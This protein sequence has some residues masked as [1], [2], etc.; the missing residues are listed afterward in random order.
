MASLCLLNV[1]GFSQKKIYKIKPGENIMDFIP[2]EEVYAYASF[3]NGTVYLKGDRYSNAKLNYNALFGD[4]QFI[5]DQGDTLGLADEKMIQS[6]VINHDT[7]YYDKGYLKL[8]DNIGG[9]KLASMKVFSF[10]NR[11]KVGGF[12]ELSNGSI[13]TYDKVSVNNYNGDL[14]ARAVLTLTENN[15]FYIGDQFN[16]FRLASRK[17]LL[18]FFAKKQ[19]LLK[20]YWLVLLRKGT[21]RM[22]DSITAASIQ[23]GHMANIRKLGSAG[24]L[25][26]AGP[27]GDD[28]DLRVI[29]ILDAKDSATAAAYINTDPAVKAGRLRFE[30]HPWWTQTGTYIFK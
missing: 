12:G 8:L 11:Q 3:T 23:E 5:T 15:L 21:N 24:V 22:Q 2:R 19:P 30:L 1:N 29:F 25:L 26:M 13:D 16:H 18:D 27:M 6:I 28:T 10:T 4:M 14:V 9:I 20:Q 17:N 7:F